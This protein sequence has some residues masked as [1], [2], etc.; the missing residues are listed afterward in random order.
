MVLPAISLICRAWSQV[1]L[2]LFSSP[3]KTSYRLYLAKSQQHPELKPV[4]RIQSARFRP[5]VSQRGRE[6]LPKAT[7]QVLWS[8]HFNSGC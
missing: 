4:S 6:H 8:A 7:C 2:L 1:F 3:I 5:E